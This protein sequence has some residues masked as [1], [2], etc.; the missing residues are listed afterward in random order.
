MTTRQPR[1]GAF[2]RARTLDDR[3]QRLEQQLTRGIA[4]SD[5]VLAQW[6]AR[7]GDPARALLRRHQRYHEGLEKT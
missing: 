5:T 6:I 4:I 7:Y 2:H 1:P 3:L